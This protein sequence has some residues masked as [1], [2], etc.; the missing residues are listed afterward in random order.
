MGNIATS[1]GNIET[2]GDCFGLFS[3]AGRPVIALVT[4]PGPKAVHNYAHFRQDVEFTK[5][6]GNFLSYMFG[7][8]YLGN[9]HC[10][11]DL[12][13]KGL[14]RGD[15]TSAHSIALKNG[16]TK[17]CQLVLTFEDTAASKTKIDK[18][19][20]CIFKKRWHL[21]SKNASSRRSDSLGM[22]YDEDTKYPIYM[23]KFSVRIHSFFYSDAMKEQPIRCSLKILPGKSPFRVALEQN[24]A[25]DI[26]M[27]YTLMA[28][29]KIQYDVYEPINESEI[30]LPEKIQ[31]QLIKLSEMAAIES[32]I[33][34][35]DEFIL[36]STPLAIG[37]NVMTVAY[38]NIM[39]YQ[40]AGV[41]LNQENNN[42]HPV[43]F[44][45]K[46]LSQDYNCDLL[47]VY[48]M[49]RK[50]LG[51]SSEIKEGSIQ[52][53]RSNS[54]ENGSYNLSK[55]VDGEHDQDDLDTGEFTNI[56]EEEN[57]GV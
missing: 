8:N 29:S 25:I 39:P 33:K 10:H 28:D 19:R 50:I 40:I 12:G 48:K 37:E 47:E 35:D 15:I 5:R 32:R 9:H 42:S 4:P 2:G 11:H 52:E 45:S 20:C 30:K 16:Y 26:G 51:K 49:A 36:I 34:L 31:Y 55:R 3:H 21:C 6:V 24:K 14:S 54:H 7:L 1:F 44:T 22:E 41:F 43:D 56:K 13:I 18:C 53:K 57:G 46:L 17:M 38:K 23:Q 27:K